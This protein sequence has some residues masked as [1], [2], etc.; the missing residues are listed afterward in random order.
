M[1]T[2]RERAERA[3]EEE[4]IVLAARINRQADAE[5]E[6]ERNR[7]R[8]LA[9]QRDAVMHQIDVLDCSI[10]RESGTYDATH[11]A[12]LRAEADRIDAEIK[13]ETLSGLLASG[14]TREITIARRADW[15][16]RN[17]I[18]STLARNEAEVGYTFADLRNAV[19]A[20]GLTK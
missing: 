14:R 7:P 13:A 17:V 4:D 8:T 9:E 18:A 11:I 20:H 16:S 3:Y 15:N 10:A 1:M 12:A 6:A 2:T 5:D 19:V